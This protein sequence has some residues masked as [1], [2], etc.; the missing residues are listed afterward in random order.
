MTKLLLVRTK[1]HWRPGLNVQQKRQASRCGA[2]SA[3]LAVNLPPRLLSFPRSRPDTPRSHARCWRR[4]G[5]AGASTL[6]RWKHCCSRSGRPESADRCDLGGRRGGHT[7]LNRS[8]FF[9]VCAVLFGGTGRSAKKGA[10]REACCFRQ[11]WWW[12]ERRN[13]ACGIRGPA[14]KRLVKLFLPRSFA[15]S[16]VCPEGR[17]L[18][19][20]RLPCSTPLLISSVS[21]LRE[22]GVLRHPCVVDYMLLTPSLRAVS[23]SG[24]VSTAVRC[25]NS[26]SCSYPGG[27]GVRAA[28]PGR[29]RPRPAVRRHPQGD[30]GGLAPASA[31]QVHS[32]R[33]THFSR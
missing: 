9:S 11:Q 21:H 28:M 6:R 30:L 18:S 20:A 13:C 10:E 5:W 19:Y 8:A 17:P 27:R 4:C 7:P 14:E 16:L 12:R 2:F 25:T 32:K 31:R 3:F 29:E 1:G 24:C 23:L 22:Q 15:R 33:Y 26:N